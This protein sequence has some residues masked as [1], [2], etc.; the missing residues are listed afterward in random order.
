MLKTLACF[1][2]VIDDADIK[3]DA[4][5]RKLVLDRA[6]YKI[7]AYDRNAIEEAV[8]L[9]ETHGGTVAAL[10][11]AP[12]GAKACLKDALSRGPDAAWFINDPAFAGLSPVQTA[13]LLAAAIRTGIEYDLIIC[14]EGS[15]DLYTQQVGPLLAEILEIPC[16]TYV[17]KLSFSAGEIIAERKLEEGIETVGVKLPAL[18]TILPDINTPRIPSLKQV[19][20]AAKKPVHNLGIE[21]LGPVGDPRL[22]TVEV[23]AATMDRKRI[24][25]PADSDGIRAAVAALMKEGVIRGV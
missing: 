25:F 20:G 21:T 8:R 9:Q 18:V 19:L 16:V 15:G 3:V 5:S 2:W 13:S 17:N 24:R 22:K 12:P 7:S 4:A 11:V 10:T 6:G 14:G 23:L 1:K